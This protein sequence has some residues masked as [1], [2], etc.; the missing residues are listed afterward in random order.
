MEYEK[1]KDTLLAEVDTG[2]KFAQSLDKTAEFEIYLYY[3]SNSNVVIKQGVVEAT[4]GIVTGTAVRA[5]KKQR[6]SFS[7]S[8]GISSARIKRSLQE[9]VSSLKSMSEKDSRFK[10]FCDPKPPGKEGKFTSEILSLSTEDLVKYTLQI[11]GDMTN[12]NGRIL[13]GADCNVSWGGFAIGNTQGLQRASSSA[14]NACSAFAMAIDGEERKTASEEFVTREKAIDVTGLGEKAS[15]KA[16]DLLGAKKF[17]KTMTL[18]TLWVPWAA[19]SYILSSLRQSVQGRNVVE[20]LSPLSQKLGDKI[21]ALSFTL[22]DDGQDPLGI[23]TEAIDAE[24]HPQDRTT[25]IDKGVLKNFLFDSYYGRIVGKESTGNSARAGGLF[26]SSLPYEYAPLISSKTL[27]VF[28]GTKTEEELIASIDG[29]ALLIADIP[30]GIFHSS[31]ATGEF[32]SVANSAY[33]I[34]NGEKQMPLEPV[35]V[36]GNF[37]KGLEQL[38]SIG[39]NMEMTSLSVTTPSLLIDGFSLTG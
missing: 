35:S 33:L 23:A 9:A 37:Y 25:I 36:A 4:D 31:V 34:K 15:K 5:A 29:Q 2:L 27:E 26:G 17:G 20:K 22:I 7:S 11:M 8:S 16:V 28:P 32:S 13:G 38:L 21:A 6:V 1:I 18:P 14:N 19:A 24:G 12:T 30:I 3:R 39:N 10:G